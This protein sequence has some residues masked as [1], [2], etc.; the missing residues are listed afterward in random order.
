ML[1]LEYNGSRIIHFKGSSML[2]Y[3]SAYSRDV[4]FN[5]QICTIN[6]LFVEVN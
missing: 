2:V 4:R 1:L 3:I 6:G 5:P